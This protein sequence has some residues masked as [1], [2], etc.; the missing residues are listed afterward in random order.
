MTSQVEICNL[1]LSNIRVGSI[2]SIDEAS[3]S[4][5]Y[6]KLKYD[7]VLDSVLRGAPW[8]F[9]RKQTALALNTDEL[10]DWAYCYQYPS[11]C[12]RINRLKS[13][14][15]RLTQAETGYAIRPEYYDQQYLQQSRNR[16]IKYAVMNASG[17]KVIGANEA[18]LW[19]DYLIRVTDPNKYDSSFILAFAWYLT[20]EIAVPI[21]GG[22]NGRAERAAAFQMYK[23][24]IA[25][26]MAMDANEQE[27]GPEK[28]SEFIEARY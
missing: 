26:A 27:N 10:F 5:Q 16:K 3:V 20:A 13:R 6:C 25:E 15:D 18:E 9:A 24:T 22:D 19:I 2:N 12:L 23:A 7:I 17:N 4:A 8:N 28:E 11:D 1:A 21:I 14:H